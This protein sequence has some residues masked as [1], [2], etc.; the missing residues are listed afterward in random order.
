MNYMIHSR[1]TNAVEGVSAGELHARVAEL[2]GRGGI[3]AV[4]SIAR[5]LRERGR[6]VVATNRGTEGRERFGRNLIIES[7]VCGISAKRYAA[8]PEFMRTAA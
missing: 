6:V 2:S 1:T 3:L 4:P 7:T 8:K 5:S